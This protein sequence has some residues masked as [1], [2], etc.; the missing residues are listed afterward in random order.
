MKKRIYIIYVLCIICCTSYLNAQN[1]TGKAD[2]G[3]YMIG[4]PIKYY[5]EIPDSKANL[6]FTSDF[7]FSD[8]LMLINSSVD[9]SSGKIK[10][11]YTF[12]SFFE[13]NH[14]LPEFQFYQAN[15]AKQVYNIVSPVVEISSPVIDTVNIET[16]QLK[17]IIKVPPTFKEV[18]P[19]SLGALLAAIITIAVIYFF[20]KKKQ[21]GSVVKTQDVPSV[22]EDTEALD[23]LNKLKQARLIENNQTKQHY[24]LL[25]EILWQ[26][27]FR[28]FDINAV[29]MTTGQIMESLQSKEISQDDIKTLNNI[30]STSDF[31]KFAK[32]LPDIQTNV[33]LMEDSVN[34]VKHNGSSITDE[35]PTD[36]KEE[37]DA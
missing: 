4:E 11:S 15:T 37:D 24:I 21:Q 18:L 34:I 14:K 31:V 3:K 32:Y 33:K 28:R 35:Q 30:F 7:H 8:T 36:K 6:N 5:F 16:K 20:K 26:Y 12:A 23:N 25:S 22:P 29:E 17:P 2:K 27:I 10:Y 13:G 1:L 9:T 19:F